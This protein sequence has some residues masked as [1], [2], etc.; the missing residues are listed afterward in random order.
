VTT[1]QSSRSSN[2]NASHNSGK[3]SNIPKR[4]TSSRYSPSSLDT[5][6][7]VISDGNQHFGDN[8]RNKHEQFIK[9]AMN[10]DDLKVSEDDDVSNFV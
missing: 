5:A 1:K 6:K 3:Q 9:D 10:L 4:L 7:M 2:H 8:A